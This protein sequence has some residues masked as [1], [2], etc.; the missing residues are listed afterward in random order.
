MSI[1]DPNRTAQFVRLLAA[2]ERRLAGYVLALVP[3][4][5]DADEILQ[6]TKLRL[7]DQFEKYDPQ[8]DFGAWARAVAY[9]QVLTFRKKR[10]RDRVL[11]S[12]DFVATLADEAAS[13]GGEASDRSSELLYCLKRLNQKY[14]ALLREFYG[15]PSTLERAAE[16][17]NMTAAAARKALARSRQA[18]H[19]CI[20]RR[21]LREEA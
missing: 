7:W 11:F 17:V 10:G 14:Q 3:N 1:D 13:R 15:R 20:E 18:L 21:L 16:T 6:E 5:V 9:Y 2:S 8:K 19:E 12:T 4:F